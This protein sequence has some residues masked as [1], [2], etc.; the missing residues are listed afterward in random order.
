MLEKNTDKIE[1]NNILKKIIEWSFCGIVAV[2]LAIIIRYYL[3]A[4]A[5]I[6]QKSMYP[7]LIDEEKILLNRINR[8]FNK[9]YERGQIITFEAPGIS[10]NRINTL[11]P[12]ATYESNTTSIIEK[13]SYEFLDIGKKS[14]IK[15]I[16]GIAGDKIR[17]EDG[18]VY[19]NE[20]KL[21]ETYLVPGTLTNSVNYNNI[22]VPEGYVFVMGDNRNESIDSRNFG[23]IPIDK[24]EGIVCFRYWPLN[25]FGKI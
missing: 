1:N 21:E 18:M 8:T 23:C 9:E 3:I 20:K 6:K 11:N 10:N 7:L 15:R 14:Y 16:I 17:I 5:V 22:T 25:K 13:F 24:I 2:F 12:V 19:I 4:P